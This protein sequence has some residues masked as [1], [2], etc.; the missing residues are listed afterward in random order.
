M[1][2]A[3]NHASSTSDPQAPEV[4]KV[5]RL[6]AETGAGLEGRPDLQM[7]DGL[8]TRVYRRSVESLGSRSRDLRLVHPEAQWKK[9]ARHLSI[10]RL[11]LAA[12]MVFGFALAAKIMLDAGSPGANESLVLQ[13]IEPILASDDATQVIDPDTADYLALL[14]T[15]VDANGTSRMDID[16]E[17]AAIERAL[18][19]FE[20]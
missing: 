19:T 15:S 4:R 20:R 9:D 10:S 2:D 8:V 17:F 6:L 14:D 5:E 18:A 12:A 13:P 1:P 3:R 16:R 11:A 7:P